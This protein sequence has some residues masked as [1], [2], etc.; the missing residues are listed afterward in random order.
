MNWSQKH[1]GIVP[2]NLIKKLS[3]RKLE[4]KIIL[5]VFALFI[6]RSQEV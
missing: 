2:T 4:N 6:N 1:P 3:L 5:H